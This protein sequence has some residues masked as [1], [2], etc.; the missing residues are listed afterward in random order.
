MFEPVFVDWN[1]QRTLKICPVGSGRLKVSMTICCY[2][3][4]CPKHMY[5]FKLVG[6]HNYTIMVHIIAVYFM[7]GFVQTVRMTLVM[8]SLLER[9]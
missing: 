1:Y 4:F 8:L 6:Q 7:L 5:V 3:L 2:C 9:S